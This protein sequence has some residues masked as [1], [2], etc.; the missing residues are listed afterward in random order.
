MFLH[1]LTWLPTHN[2]RRDLAPCMLHHS[3][4]VYLSER[5]SEMLLDANVL[6][7]LKFKKEHQAVFPD[8]N[9]RV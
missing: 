6:S 3:D 8:L 1:L 4:Q 5:L 9:V 7:H 2:V